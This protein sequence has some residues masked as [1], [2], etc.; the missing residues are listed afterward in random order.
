VTGEQPVQEGQGT[1]P[2]QYLAPVDVAVHIEAG[3]LQGRPSGQVIDVHGPDRSVLT[4]PADLDECREVGIGGG[5]I[6]QILLDLRE[7][8]VVVEGDRRRTGLGRAGCGCER[9]QQKRYSGG[10]EKTVESILQSRKDVA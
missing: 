9:G 10:R 4:A 8:V 2:A 6:L 5:Y 7:G 3:L 1:L